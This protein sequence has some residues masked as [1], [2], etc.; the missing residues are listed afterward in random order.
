M[1]EKTKKY[2]L[3]LEAYLTKVRAP[4]WKRGIHWKYEPIYKIN[5]FH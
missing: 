3:T 4:K 1:T 5:S 2:E